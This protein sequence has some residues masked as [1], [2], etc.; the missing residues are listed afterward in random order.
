MSEPIRILVVDDEPDVEMLFRQRF[1]RELREG[2]FDISFALSGEQALQYLEEG[3]HA[4]PSLV[5]SDINMPGMTGLQLLEKVKHDYPQLK[6]VMIS[7]YAR[8]DYE[9]KARSLGADDFIPKPIDF[10]LLT[11]RLKEFR[12]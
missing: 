3:L 12:S 4:K 7:A 1:R 8:S 9:T 2:L 11:D 10:H 5:L 6:I